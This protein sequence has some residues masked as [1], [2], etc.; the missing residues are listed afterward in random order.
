[1]YFTLFSYTT[2]EDPLTLHGVFPFLVTVAM[3]Y[4]SIVESKRI[5]EILYKKL[6]EKYLGL[7]CE[8][9]ED[10]HI[11]VLKPRYLE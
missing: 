2:A 1:V 6:K 9:E 7:R 3:F 4:Y 8:M 10:I 5:E 11:Y